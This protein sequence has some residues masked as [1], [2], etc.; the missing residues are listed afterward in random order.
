MRSI[1]VRTP[2][3]DAAVMVP[4]MAA[5]VLLPTQS[6]L[7]ES[8]RAAFLRLFER[9]VRW[10]LIAGF[11]AALAVVALAPFIV[12]LIYAPN[13]AQAA[14]ILQILILGASLMVVDQMLSTTQIAAKAQRADL[15]RQVVFLDHQVGPHQ[16]QQF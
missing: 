13:L 12:H 1:Q 5:I 8:D 3:R 16:V 6:R 15:H 11:A 9:A 7:F 14:S 4:T 2:G 10:Y